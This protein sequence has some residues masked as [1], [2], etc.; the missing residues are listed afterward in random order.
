[1]KYLMSNINSIFHTENGFKGYLIGY[2]RVKKYLISENQCNAI[3][4][5]FPSNAGM[6]QR[7]IASLC[8]KET[9]V[10]YHLIEPLYSYEMSGEEF[11]E[12][13][14]A[15]L[16]MWNEK[17]RQ[18]SFFCNAEGDEITYTGDAFETSRYINREIH[19]NKYL[20]LFE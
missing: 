16:I 2:S 7:V 1:M 14:N 15:F 19:M 6:E 20:Y 10:R 11:Q 17:H 4:C 9:L 3:H 13:L 8:D 5:K 12:S 18:A